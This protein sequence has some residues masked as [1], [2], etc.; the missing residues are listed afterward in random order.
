LGVYFINKL[1]GWKHFLI[2]LSL[3]PYYLL[4]IIMFLY[5]RCKSLVVTLI[6]PIKYVF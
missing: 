3:P 2:Y 5:C 4:L 6:K 1:N